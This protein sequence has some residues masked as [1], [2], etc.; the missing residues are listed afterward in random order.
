MSGRDADAN[1]GA[2]KALGLCVLPALLSIAVHGGM[3]DALAAAVPLPLRTPVA[4]SSAA[5]PLSSD[6]PAGVGV[7]EAPAGGPLNPGVTPMP[8]PASTGH[9]AAPAQQ[10]A[11]LMM[12][13]RR[14]P[15]AGEHLSF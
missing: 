6:R 12:L 13:S 2:M 15:A 7:P 9:Y 8:V 14:S 5:A 4:P 1:P 10:A 11:G 3:P